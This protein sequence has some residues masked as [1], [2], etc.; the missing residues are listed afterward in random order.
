MK[1]ASPLCQCSWACPTLLLSGAPLSTHRKVGQAAE[2]LELSADAGAN[3][4]EHCGVST[5]GMQWSGENMEHRSLLQKLDEQ[6]RNLDRELAR[7]RKLL[8]RQHARRPASWAVAQHLA[9]HCDDNCV[10]ALA[11]L[12]R[13][14]PEGRDASR[15]EHEL[16]LWRR[17]LHAD[18]VASHRQRPFTAQ[19]TKTARA[20]DAF[21]REAALHDWVQQQNL[22][23]GIAPTSSTL[24]LSAAQGVE[25]TAAVLRGTPTRKCALQWLR[26]WRRRWRITLGQIPVRDDVPVA[27]RR[28]KA[29]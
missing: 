3:S 25:A 12:R 2:R 19:V 26:R 7:S 8:H 5:L 4:R 9:V 29:R 21:L 24:S 1:P 27:D 11:Y 28:A 16:R 17:G 23:A 10:S 15:S 22:T 13:T 6:R 18:D 14:A 20:A